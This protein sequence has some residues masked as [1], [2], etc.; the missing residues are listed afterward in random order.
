MNDEEQLEYDATVILQNAVLQYMN[1]EDEL[2]ED[3]ESWNELMKREEDTFFAIMTEWYVQEESTFNHD[4]SFETYY[5]I[6]RHSPAVMVADLLRQRQRR[7]RFNLR[8]QYWLEKHP[9]FSEEDFKK[10]YRVTKTTFEHL[11]SELSNC[12]EYVG[13]ILRGGYPVEIQLATVLWRFSNTHFGYRIANVHLGVPAG[14]YNNF[15]NRFIDAMIKISENIIKWP[16]NDPRRADEIA[17]GFAS[18]GGRSELKLAK[19][20]GAVD[21][22]LVVIQKPSKN[23][24]TYVDRKGNA[25]LSL[26]GICDHLGRFT[27]LKCGHSGN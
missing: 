26:L 2:M 10:H 4:I 13:S 25:S 23:G 8:E 19:I 1:F 22:K 14:S 17:E 24:N 11:V 21:G 27:F 16:V 3:D 7:G 12:S 18:L 6:Y 20:L 15:T 9:I 5:E